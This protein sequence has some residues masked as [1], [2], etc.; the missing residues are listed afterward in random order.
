MDG[1]VD[2]S[3]EPFV[4]CYECPMPFCGSPADMVHHLTD[5]CS[6]HCWPLAENIKY[7]TCYPFTMPESLEDHRRLL[8]SEEDG[9]VFLL[10]VGTGEARAG[11]R[12]VS[13]VCVRGDAADADTDTRPMY[14]CVVSV[15][16]PPGRVGGDTGLIERTWT[17]GSWDYPAN[18][19]LENPW[20][21]LPADAVHGDSKEVHLEV[22]IIKLNVDH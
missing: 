22:R 17:L 3:K 12:P 6:G 19:D 13:V 7:E 14:G 15:T 8:V 10:I 9:S 4:H 18:V 2:A 21:P 11:R 20:H 16:T 1:L 5:A